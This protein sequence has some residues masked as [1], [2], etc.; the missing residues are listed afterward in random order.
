MTFKQTMIGLG[1]AVG[2]LPVLALAQ[3]AA[4]TVKNPAPNASNW[5]M[6][7]GVSYRD[8]KKLE[9]QAMSLRNGFGANDGTSGG[10]VGIQG[11]DAAT[12]TAYGVV[13]PVFPLSMPI[14]VDMA[15]FQGSREKA[16]SSSAIAPVI[17]LERALSMDDN[18]IISL[19]GNLQY[20]NVS[21]E[22]SSN[23]VASS[24][25]H[26]FFLPGPT[27]TPP[28]A[29]GGVQNPGTNINIKSKFDMDLFVF[30][31]GLKVATNNATS[32]FDW[33][34]AAGP[35]LA[36]ANSDASLTENETWA[37]ITP[38]DPGAAVAT[39]K[40]SGLDMAIGVYGA[41]GMEYRL[42][43][44]WSLGLE[45]RYDAAFSKIGN[46]LAKLDLNGPSLQLKIIYAF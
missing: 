18:R 10:R 15:T 39:H 20:H 42:N 23:V 37:P 45:G 2:F 34:A 41:L 9:F 25:T 21:T 19:V 13:P 3:D 12:L 44:N 22:G 7:L 46:D 11:Y 4:L 1:L 38:L 14:S 30:D 31:L 17:G 26:L 29:T 36:I 40:D 8:F 33:Y 6:S 24:D 27:F 5:R 32:N 43:K 35:T 16:D 28:T